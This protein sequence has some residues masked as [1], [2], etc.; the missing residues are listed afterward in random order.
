MFFDQSPIHSRGLHIIVENTILEDY[1]SEK[2]WQALHLGSVPI[3]LGAPN[4]VDILPRGSFINLMDYSTAEGSY[5]MNAL[6]F[7]VDRALESPLELA[8]YHAWRLPN[9]DAKFMKLITR[10][11]N[12]EGFVMNRKV[13]GDRKRLTCDICSH[14]FKLQRRASSVRSTSSDSKRTIQNVTK[15]H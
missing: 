11:G 12:S 3:Y 4:V 6:K 5:D 8:R 14:I 15:T 1:V 10:F 7:A 2:A 9:V 13:Y